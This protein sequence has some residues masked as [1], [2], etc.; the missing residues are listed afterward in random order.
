M[1]QE[2][3]TCL[4]DKPFSEWPSG[5]LRWNMRR[6]R[7]EGPVSDIKAPILIQRT[8]VGNILC[9]RQ[10]TNYAGTRGII[11]ICSFD[12]SVDAPC[13]QT[14]ACRV[15]CPCSRSG[16]VNPQNSTFVKL[17]ELLVS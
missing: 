11:V 5:L 9:V 2:R 1:S 10:K 17:R 8:T 13:Q 3:R 6:A 4:P 16:F 15:C 12:K 7:R 14:C